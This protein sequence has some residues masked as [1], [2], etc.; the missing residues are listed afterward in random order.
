MEAKKLLKELS[1]KEK[2]SLCSGKDNW[3]T[4]NIDRLG[5]SSINISEGQHGLQKTNKS[6]R[7]IN[8]SDIKKSTCFPTASLAACVWDNTLLYRM[9]VAIAE[10]A[11]QE[12]V[13]IVLGPQINIKRSPLCGRNFEYFSEDPLL[14]GELAASFIQGIQSRGIGASLKHF[15]INNQETEKF[16]SNAVVDE[17]ALHEIYLYG[18][19]I[20][21]K[22]GRPWTI[23]TSYNMINGVYAT[24][25]E[26]LLKDLLRQ[27]WGYRGLIISGSG[28]V[29]NISKSIHSGLNI[30]MPS[31]HGYT[32]KKIV[33]AIRTKQLDIKC[34]DDVVEKNIDT[35]RNSLARKKENFEY[36]PFLHH[37]LARKIAS[38]SIIL[39]KNSGNILPLSRSAS[40]KKGIAII[41][42]YAKYPRIQA[43]G[44][45]S[46]N[47][48]KIDTV[49]EELEK[50][51]I[52]YTYARG[53]N[54]KSSENN[55]K[56]IIK[57]ALKVATDAYRVVLFIGLTDESE[58]GYIDKDNLEIPK[59]H[60]ILLDE[61]SKVNK[62]IIVVLYGCSTP[63]MPW[64]SK[65]KGLLHVYLGGEAISSAI[66]DILL[67]DVNPSGK[68]TETYPT[69][70]KYCPSYNYF[71]KEN[72]NV[73][74]RESIF[75]GYRYYQM[76]SDKDK[77]E[78][79]LFP[80]G[81]GLSYT[82]FEYK[83][84]KLSE[85]RTTDYNLLSRRNITVTFE[86]ENIG[87]YN[88]AEVV[89]LYISQKNPA[90]FKPKRELRGFEKVFLKK[91]EKKSISFKISYRSF[92]YYNI[93]KKN[94]DIEDGTYIVELGTNSEHILLSEKLVIEKEK[95]FDSKSQYDIKKLY[96]YYNID[97]VQNDD[98]GF[99]IE[100]KYFD[101][102]FED[103]NLCM[104]DTLE[105]TYS[106]NSTLEEIK[107]TF[108]GKILYKKILKNMEIVNDESMDILFKNLVKEQPLRMYI[109]SLGSNGGAIVEAFIALL[110]KKY[111][112]AIKFL[113]YYNYI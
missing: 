77:K 103:K 101:A 62:N 84:I 15:A 55:N 81:F 2:S 37:S 10:E 60:Q 78:Q 111:L 26:W 86:L 39:L 42:E 93:I 65:T 33:H 51:E 9:G 49:L 23:M 73:E 113:I 107:D 72:L 40:K 6:E 87:N 100:D 11:L 110:N 48:I 80:F 91:G 64:L 12:S 47:A 8:L 22:K 94:W 69:D 52:P 41:G 5:I 14:S 46:V 19:E 59:S 70:V 83:N 92:A 53:Y 43:R 66:V 32:V 18:F 24:E 38:E 76:L 67:G 108:F 105:S 30:E 102:L 13:S 95:L 27:K 90:I 20:A 63:V 1:L 99:I 21:V 50:N 97:K 4:K 68:T 45:S 44:S 17:R 29:N 7:N 56:S 79:V 25:N 85:K 106:L 16:R 89:Q 28:S 98:N 88:G 104:Q 57:E 109:P 82:S 35:I 71:A 3:H 34:L 75:V 61:I 36:N 54:S 31:T 74:Y 58:N 96:P 112:K